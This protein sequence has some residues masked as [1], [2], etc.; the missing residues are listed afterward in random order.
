MNLDEVEPYL[1]SSLLQGY[2]LNSNLNLDWENN[3]PV[4]LRMPKGWYYE[5]SQAG[6][7]VNDTTNCV[8]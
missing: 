5:C 2:F 7:L 4:T 3:F 8:N 6:F 1:N